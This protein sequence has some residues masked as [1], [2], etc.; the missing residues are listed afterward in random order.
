MIWVTQSKNTLCFS[1]FRKK[2]NIKKIRDEITIDLDKLKYSIQDIDNIN[3]LIKLNSELNIE[4][5]FKGGETEAWQR[6]NHY[7]YEKN[8]YQIIKRLETVS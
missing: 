1:N 6:L 8:Y 2:L 3:S 7:F 4:V 5:K